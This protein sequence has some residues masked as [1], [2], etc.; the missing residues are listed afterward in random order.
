MP[1]PPPPTTTSLYF[2]SGAA[3][4]L[5]FILLG[6]SCSLPYREGIGPKH[7]NVSPF[8]RSRHPPNPPKYGREIQGGPSKERSSAIAGSPLPYLASGSRYGEVPRPEQDRPGQC[9]FPA[10][11]WTSQGRGGGLSSTRTPTLRKML[12]LFDE[13]EAPII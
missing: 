8:S 12:C 11:R 13:R 10:L 4:S 1:T 2:S 3:P 5:G 7:S 6:K 9:S